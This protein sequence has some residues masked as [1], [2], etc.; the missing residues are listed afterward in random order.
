MEG[1]FGTTNMAM[2]G[3]LMNQWLD[4][5]RAW[6]PALI[7]GLGG[8]GTE[9]EQLTVEGIHGHKDHTAYVMGNEGEGGMKGGREG[10]RYAYSISKFTTK[11]MWQTLTRVFEFH[12]SQRNVLELAT[13]YNYTCI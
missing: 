4:R 8:D 2:I 5:L 10:G 9:D 11:V 3:S 7:H 6:H 12:W 13:F 1:N